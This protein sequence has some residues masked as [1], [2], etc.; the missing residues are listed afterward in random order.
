MQEIQGKLSEDLGSELKASGFEN[1]HEK[2]LQQWS[3]HDAGELGDVTD[4]SADV[5]SDE[6]AD[7][8]STATENEA[9]DFASVQR[10][11]DG[12]TAEAQP[13]EGDT[14]ILEGQAASRHDK[15]DTQS[16]EKLSNFEDPDKPA[17]GLERSNDMDRDRDRDRIR[18]ESHVEEVQDSTGLELESVVHDKLVLE[19]RKA[20]QAQRIRN[21]VRSAHKSGDKRTRSRGGVNIEY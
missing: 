8:S 18:N 19:K 16:P 17:V 4:D 7:G 14:R 15:A 10:D 13:F 12:Q 5:S 21:A 3:A 20:R 1:E 2:A 6:E 11:N 9:Q